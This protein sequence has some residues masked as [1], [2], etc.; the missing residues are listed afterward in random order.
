MTRVWRSLIAL[1][2][3]ATSVGGCD[4]APGDT[5]TE[6]TSTT[7]SE[8]PLW[9][10]D[11]IHPSFLE[12]P[13]DEGLLMISG[14]SR[15][16]RVVDLRE[17]WALDSAEF[18]WSLLAEDAPLDAIVN[19]GA[20]AESGRVVAFN[21]EPSETWSFDP[22]GRVWE[23]MH[24][25]VQP[26]STPDKPRFGAPLTY[27]SESDRLILYAGGSPWHMYTDTWAYDLNTDTW[28]PMSPKS[29]PS[30]R[31]MYA[32]AYDTES[33]RVLL[34]GGFTGTEENDVA[35]WAYDYNTDTWERLE[36]SGGPQQHWERHGMAYI[37]ELDQVLFYSGMLEE[38]GVLPAET[39]YYDYNSNAWTAI[40]V[41]ISPP[42]LAMY[43][44]A[45][46]S[47]IGKAVL[48]GG[49]KTSKYAGDISPD[50]WVFDPDTES[51][52]PVSAPATR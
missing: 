42:A 14:M 22:A 19:F 7:A 50:I 1:A 36:N 5:A 24:P 25:G 45:Y 41:A 10:S 4:T 8:E 51:W 40:D 15:M 21:I 28:E 49:E 46:D 13:T 30:P 9:P 33:D 12:D 44:M 29:S 3:A 47:R 26:S 17:V 35:M 52:A 23:Q 38:E 6:R 2:L 34:W 48:F 32:T 16:Q 39:W 31:G 11:R 43:A 18:S 37:P 20:D 27:D